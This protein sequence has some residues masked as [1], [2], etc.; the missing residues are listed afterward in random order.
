M[1]RLKRKKTG[2]PFSNKKE[3]TFFPSIQKKVSVGKADDK[4]EKEADSVANKIVNKGEGQGSIQKMESSEEEVQQKPLAASITPMVQRVK[5]PEEEPTVQK[6]EKVEEEPIQKVEEEEPVQK[7]EE[8]EEEGPVQKQE[9]EEMAQPKKEEEES[10]QKQEE[11]EEESMQMKEEE[12]E[13]SVQKQEEEEE[14]LQTK[15]NGN[16][17]SNHSIESKLK[18]RKGFGNKLSGKTKNV[19]ESGF[20]ADFSGV[21]IHTDSKAVEMSKEL[22]AQAFTHGKDVY[23]N[24]GKYNPNTKEGKHL[25]A[26]ELTHC[27]QQDPNTIRKKDANPCNKKA[28]SKARQKAYF[29]VQLVKHKL[30]GLNPS[31]GYYEQKAMMRLVRKLVSPKV[32]SIN[33]VKTLIER[34]MNVLSTDNNIICGPEINNCT[35]WNG[36]VNNNSSPIHLCNSFFS[37]GIDGQIKLLIH[38]AVHAAGIGSSA[39]EEYIPI[40]DCDTGANNYN[41]ADAWAHFIH[42]ATNQTPDKPEEVKGY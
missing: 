36:Y 39:S 9:E 17:Q 1:K 29:R 28:I 2:T 26:H 5:T 22:G 16:T 6:A 3:S 33:A 10:V 41:S 13:E 19:M 4:Y 23:F 21:N 14:M 25:L 12:E 27:I 15:R 37:L 42:C 31:T 35:A 18:S 11:E 7:Q 32:K 38:E 40:F 30:S 24:E 20:G 8:E 34:M